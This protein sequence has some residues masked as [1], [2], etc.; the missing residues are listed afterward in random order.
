MSCLGLP[1]SSKFIASFPNFGAVLA[2]E[3]K[4]VGSPESRADCYSENEDGLHSSGS[5]TQGRQNH[6]E[7]RMLTF[8]WCQAGFAGGGGKR[9]GDG[10][11]F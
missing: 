4:L 5:P 1:D 9:R 7:T 3:A 10:T 11:G 2:I 8:W 6:T